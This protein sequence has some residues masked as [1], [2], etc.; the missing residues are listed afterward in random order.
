M[1]NRS[2][3]C[4]LPQPIIRERRT[5]RYRWRECADLRCRALVSAGYSRLA[6][7]RRIVELD[8]GLRADISEWTFPRR[9]PLTLAQ[10]GGD[11]QAE[12]QAE[13]GVTRR[14]AAH[15][16]NATTTRLWG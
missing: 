5:N 16:R 11:V 10:M 3:P 12:L 7:R 15:H 2:S 8:G 14:L 6:R 13:L 9:F 4:S 1:L